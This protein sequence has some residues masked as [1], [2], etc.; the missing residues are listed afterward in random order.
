MKQI[1]YDEY[2][3][4]LFGRTEAYTDNV[5][6]LYVQAVN[7]LLD[8]ASKVDLGP[9]ETFSFAKYSKLSDKANNILRALYSHV[10]A[11]IG[12]G[13]SSEWEY[14]N[15]SCD[16]LITSIFGKKVA[17]SNLFAKL[18]ARNRD[19]LDAFTKRKSEFGGLNLSQKVWK[20]TGQLKTEMETALTV[21]LGQGDSAAQVSRNVRKYMT[22]P[23][24]LYR[25]VRDSDGNLKLS[26]AAK[27]YHP[28]QGMY[29]SSYKNAM[30]LTRTETN[31]AY[32][33]ADSDRWN[34]MNF[35][36]GIEVKTSNH[37]DADDICDDLAGRYPKDF[38][39]MGWHPQCR[40]YA[41]P[42]LAD[43]DDMLKWGND[44]LDG[45]ASYESYKPKGISETPSNY[46]RWIK[47]N[48][49]RIDNAASKPY[50]IKK[51]MKYVKKGG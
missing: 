5:R 43:L 45:K 13:I 20:Y 48:K 23:D 11:E 40:C 15:L 51:N 4:G 8:I 33:T 27:L 35:V 21:S 29:R 37:H 41:V 44:V 47:D 46:N 42:I 17:G 9:N 49:D 38:V 10:Y 32:R 28:G 18:F 31:M 7:Q 24:K 50:W 26:K 30:R 3:A 6:K 14:A 22:N 36:I 16:A 2:A 1:K 25:R 12:N 19:A 39:F 34:R